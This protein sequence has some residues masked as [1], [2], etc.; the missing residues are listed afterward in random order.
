MVKTRVNRKSRSLR[1]TRRQRGGGISSCVRRGHPN[2]F[3]LGVRKMVPIL[4]DEFQVVRPEQWICYGDTITSCMTFTVVMENN[5]KIGV[6]INPLT[7]IYSP[8]KYT[9]LNILS[10]IQEKLR[11]HPNFSGNIKAIYIFG[12]SQSFFL[13]KNTTDTYKRLNNVNSIAQIK[14]PAPR[15]TLFIAGVPAQFPKAK[16]KQIIAI[17]NSILYDKITPTTVIKI[18]PNITVESKNQHHFFILENGDLD[19]VAQDVH[20]TRT[21]TANNF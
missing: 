20:L 6:H 1:K 15:N 12:D 13:S 19:I 16:N 5:W 4:E 14:E 2:T 8:Q 18:N 17:L 21:V 3:G 10:K 11:T 7:A 9:P